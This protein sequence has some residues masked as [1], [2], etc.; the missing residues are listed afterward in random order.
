[1][2]L[3]YKNGGEV[4]VGDVLLAPD[5]KAIIVEDIASSFVYVVNKDKPRIR[6]KFTPEQLNCSIYKPTPNKNDFD[7]A[8]RKLR[9][10]W[11]G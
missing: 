1:M 4:Q 3:K 5:G 10:F 8:R 6:R 2:R 7:L 11:E 9:D